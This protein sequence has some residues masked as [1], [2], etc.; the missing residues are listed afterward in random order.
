V[1]QTNIK[2]ISVYKIQ[3]KIITCFLLFFFNIQTSFFSQDLSIGF[4]SIKL[5]TPSLNN[6][7]NH[8]NETRPWLKN[9]LNKHHFVSGISTKLELNILD[10]DDFFMIFSMSYLRNK[11][12]AKG[13]T[14]GGVDFKRRVRSQIF[15]LGLIGASYYPI[16][17]EEWKL[18]IGLNMF[19]ATWYNVHSKV[20]TNE[21]GWVKYTTDPTNKDLI[22]K[23]FTTNAFSSSI[24]INLKYNVQDKFWLTLCVHAQR[25]Y[26]DND[27]DLFKLKRDLNPSTYNQSIHDLR[28]SINNW[29]VTLYFS[30]NN[31]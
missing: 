7:I 24:E 11:S 8:Y 3:L 27:F 25:E 4:R 20:N 9:K 30:K 10:S 2:K 12:K 28:T 6:V 1:K 13:T 18:G 19:N 29:G 17:N 14:P 23:V 5:T 21:D 16:N 31:Y 22:T 15:D 26:I